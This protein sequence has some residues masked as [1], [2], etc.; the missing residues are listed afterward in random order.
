MANLQLPT[1][2]QTTEQLADRLR[3][4][5]AGYSRFILGICGAPGA[6]KSTLAAALAA[7][8]NQTEPGSAVVVGLDGFHLAYNLIADDDR[9]QRRGAPDTFDAAGYGLLL[10]RLHNGNESMVYAPEY[11]RNIEDPVAA[12]IQVPQSVRFVLTE[13]NYL[14]NPEPLWEK[15]SQYLDAIWFLDLPT[16]IRH[17]R[18]LA[19]HLAFGKDQALAEQFTFGSD[20]ANAQLIESNRDRA[21]LAILWEQ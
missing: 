11:R 10:Q 9:A 4:L 18:L 15:A 20:E 2:V 7:E 12:A 21:N 19:R 16:E 14:L 5:A 8:L 13:G 1:T 6:G 17:Q 3:D